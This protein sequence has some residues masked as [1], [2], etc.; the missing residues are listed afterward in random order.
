MFTNEH[1]KPTTRPVQPTKT[2]ISL[3]INKYIHF[4]YPSLDSLEAHVNSTVGS[5]YTDA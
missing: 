4:V 5:D 1:T 3:Y 2:Q